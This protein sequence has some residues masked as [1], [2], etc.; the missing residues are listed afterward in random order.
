MLDEKYVKYDIRKNEKAG[1]VSVFVTLS[2]FSRKERTAPI[3]IRTNMVREIL[4]DNGIE[5]DECVKA[6]MLSSVAGDK[7]KIGEW[8]F[9]VKIEK[10]RKYTPKKEV[11]VLDAK[12][13]A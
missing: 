2:P 12:H 1:V 8:V 11:E 5:H 3:R 13:D 10:K 6:D 4:N 9:K 7:E